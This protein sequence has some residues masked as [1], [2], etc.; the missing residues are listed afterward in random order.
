MTVGEPKLGGNAN[1]FICAIYSYCGY[2]SLL[3]SWKRLLPNSPNSLNPVQPLRWP[4]ATATS[5]PEVASLLRASGQHFARLTDWIWGDA[6]I[7]LA[8]PSTRP[9]LT[10]RP[11]PTP[12]PP[13]PR[14]PVLVTRHRPFIMAGWNRS[15]HPEWDA[16]HWLETASDSGLPF[17][18][19]D[20]AVDWY[21]AWFRPIEMRYR[22]GGTTTVRWKRVAE[23][24][25]KSVPST[26]LLSGWR[27]SPTATLVGGRRGSI[28]QRL[29]AG[30]KSSAT[31]RLRREIVTTPSSACQL[32]NRTQPLETTLQLR[33]WSYYSVV[34]LLFLFP[35]ANFSTRPREQRKTGSLISGPMVTTF[36][37]AFKA[38]YESK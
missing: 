23:E 35:S 9:S 32:C 13:P 21:P 38:T 3:G 1:G 26:T 34:R 15:S 31:T 14:P 12:S 6:L 37:C 28:H 2:G 22:G 17:G 8:F 24:H 27:L 20:R 30:V 18:K 29:Q 10:P 33:D 4:T 11:P 5:T 25:N 36:L 19:R 16:I 7:S